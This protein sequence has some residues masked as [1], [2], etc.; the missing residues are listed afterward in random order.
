LLK[1]TRIAFRLWNEPYH[2]RKFPLVHR[3]QPNRSLPVA[4]PVG[5][6]R[7]PLYLE[8]DKMP[9]RRR[10]AALGN[11]MTLIFASIGGTQACVSRPGAAP[12]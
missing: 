11:V 8:H 9:N 6:A 1:T 2:R 7:R 4:L 10:P 3:F 12:P 5:K